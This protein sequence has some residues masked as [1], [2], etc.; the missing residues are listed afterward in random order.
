MCWHVVT[1][2]NIDYHNNS[3]EFV[4][5][6]QFDNVQNIPISTALFEISLDLIYYH[7]ELNITSRFIF[8]KKS[9]TKL[10]LKLSI[11][12]VMITGKFKH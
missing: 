7:N 8:F 2:K 10:H 3:L 5:F 11:S 1:Y 6:F 12:K 4:F 9:K